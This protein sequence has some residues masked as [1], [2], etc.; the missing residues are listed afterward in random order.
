MINNKLNVNKKWWKES[1]VYQ[2]YPRS[3]Y[4]SN[5][6]G[7]GDLLGIIDKLDYLVQLGVDVLWIC[8]FFTSPNADNGYDIS[9]YRNIALEYGTMEDCDNLLLKAH[10]KGLKVMMD[11]VVNHSSDEHSWFVESRQSKTSDKRSYYIWRDGNSDAPPNNWMSFFG[12]DAWKYDENSEQYYLHLFTEK[13]PDLNW[14]NDSVRRE[15]YDM[16]E[17]WINKGFDGFRMDMISLISKFPDFPDGPMMPNG[18]GIP[19]PYVNNGPRIHEYLQEMNQEVLSKYDLLTV[20]ET[21]GATTEDAKKYANETGNE[22]NMV[23]QFEHMQLDKAEPGKPYQRPDLIKLKQIMNRW[24]TQLHGVAWNSLY[25]NNHDQ[26]RAVSRFGDD[27]TEEYRVN[28]AKM[29]ALCLHMMQGTPYIYQGEELGMTNIEFCSINEVK[30]VEAV[31]TY[32]SGIEAGASPE[33]M[34]QVLHYKCR[35]NAR[36]PMQWDDSEN[37]GFTSGMPW[38]RVNPNYTEINVRSQMEDSNSV[39]SFYKKLIG[40]RKQYPVITYG[41]YQ[42]LFPEDEKLFIYKREY[43]GQKLFV[44]CNFKAEKAV[45]T[46][47]NDI[48]NNIKD[49][50]ISNMDIPLNGNILSLD[51]YAT[52]AYI[53]S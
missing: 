28:S 7:I 4:D 17:Y 10:Q 40:L 49:P 23:F 20:G 31:Q 16:M 42:Q 3:F 25:W 48:A 45:I 29:L 37:A 1:V 6:D 30:D 51:P 14:E 19:F 5:G 50:L 39:L 34:L 44:V 52:S 36:T 15:V 13:Q 53:I 11:L 32:Y 47:S 22:L 38:L 9:D 8:P 2:I 41:D 26:P 27:S 46:L 21:P 35:D 33:E 43:E 24:Q 18:Y 12:G